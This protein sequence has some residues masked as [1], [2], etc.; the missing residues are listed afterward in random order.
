MIVGLCK[1]DMVLEG[2][3]SL[4]EKR[5]VVRKIK[6]SVFS[7][8]KIPVSEVGHQDLWQRAELGFA[9]VGNSKQKLNSIIDKILDRIYELGSSHLI[10]QKTEYIYFNDEHSGER[11]ID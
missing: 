5:Q 4:K 3:R 6:D 8:F 9:V 7:G 10:N 2:H 1:V 11:Y